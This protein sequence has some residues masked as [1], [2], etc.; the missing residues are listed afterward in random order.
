MNLNKRPSEEIGEQINEWPLE[1]N[2][3][4]QVK[5]TLAVVITYLDALWDTGKLGGCLNCQCKDNVSKLS[6]QCLHTPCA[7]AVCGDCE[8]KE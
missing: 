3:S 1:P 5:K 8:P 6:G 2:D 4:Y 7:G